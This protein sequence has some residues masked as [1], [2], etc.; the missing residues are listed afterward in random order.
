MLIGK[1]LIIFVIICHKIYGHGK[2]SKKND[3]NLPDDK[4]VFLSRFNRFLAEFSRGLSGDVFME[5]IEQIDL[6]LDATIFY[7]FRN[8]IGSFR[9]IFS[10]QKKIVEKLVKIVKSFRFCL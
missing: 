9:C 4:F 1:K 10:E 6:I 2:D 3:A 5:E 8:K 7:F